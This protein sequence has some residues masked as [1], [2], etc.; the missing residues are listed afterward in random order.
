MPDSLTRLP[1]APRMPG[2]PLD[3]L[4]PTEYRTA[5]R[6]GVTG[7][8][9]RIR[10]ASYRSLPLS[11]LREISLSIDGEPIDPAGLRLVLDGSAFA[12]ADLAERTDVWWY[13]LDLAEL[14]VPSR[15]LDPGTHELE[16]SMTALVPYATGG[17]RT[18]TVRSTLQ[19]TV[20]TEDPS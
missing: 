14:F 6:N 3:F 12:L 8:H 5:V 20:P 10:L 18:S 1:S 17:R 9:V 2:Q 15:P 13:I 11:C 7:F 4:H 16:A 19:I